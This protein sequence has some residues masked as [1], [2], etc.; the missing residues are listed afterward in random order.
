MFKSLKKIRPVLVAGILLCCAIHAIVVIWSFSGAS[1]GPDEK[2]EVYL[3]P[4]SHCDPGW[5]LTWG[6]Y[7]DSRVKHILRGVVSALIRDER[8]KFTWAD[9]SFLAMWSV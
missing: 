5:K 3:V 8:R 6:Q 4:H 2:I 7:Y 1:V 9:I